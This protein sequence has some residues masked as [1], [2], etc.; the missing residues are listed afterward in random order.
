MVKKHNLEYEV[1]SDPG[2]KVAEQYGLVYTVD[3]ETVKV[4]KQYNVNLPE[5]NADGTW[6]LP[7]PATYVIG[8]DG[9][10]SWAYA[11]EDY[12]VRADPQD[13]VAA[14]KQLIEH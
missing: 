12:K 6:R 4:Y 14:L 7:V 8:Q 5:Y 10:I 11:N 9:V 13:I 3:K 2:F 1:V